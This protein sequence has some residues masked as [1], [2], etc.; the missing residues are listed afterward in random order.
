MS[1]VS[2][3]S[4]FGLFSLVA[5]GCGA[6]PDAPGLGGEAPTISALDYAPK[7]AM[8]GSKTV[9]VGSLTI[10]DADAD[11]AELAIEVTPPGSSTPIA[12][13]PTPVPATQRR[14]SGTL[15]LVVSFVAPVAGDYAFVLRAVDAKGHESNPLTGLVHAR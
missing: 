1:Q 9:L 13:P 12:Y 2:I 5:L 6:A 14:A 3:S 11:I 15:D 10:E 4:V 8:V 7:E